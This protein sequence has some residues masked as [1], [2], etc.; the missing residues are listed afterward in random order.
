MELKVYVFFHFYLPKI[1]NIY[2]QMNSTDHMRSWE[3]WGYSSV[4]FFRSWM[5][6][7]ILPVQNMAIYGLLKV[8]L[9]NVRFQKYEEQ[10]LTFKNYSLKY[11]LQNFNLKSTLQNLSR[12]IWPLKFVLQNYTFKN[13]DLQNVG[14]KNWQSPFFH[15]IFLRELMVGILHVVLHVA[16]LIFNIDFLTEFFLPVLI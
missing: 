14:F 6:T 5:Y 10:H 11:D 8:T 16:T 4:Y 2:G 1:N 9:Q 12:E 15:N 7:Q 3:L 13:V